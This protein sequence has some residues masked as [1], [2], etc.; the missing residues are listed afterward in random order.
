[1]KK[2]LGLSVAILVLLAGCSKE[3]VSV[4]QPVLKGGGSGTNGGYAWGL[5]TE[6]SGS[7]SLTFPDSRSIKCTWKNFGD[8]GF[9]KGWKPSSVKTVQYQFTEKSGTMN[10]IGIYGWTRNPLLE[11]YIATVGT[12]SG[13]TNLGTMSSYGFT[14]NCRKLQRVNAP[15]I[16]GTKTF[17]QA[18]NMRQ[19]QGGTGGTKTCVMSDHVNFWKSKGISWGS[20][21]YDVMVECESWAGG[22]GSCRLKILN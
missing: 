22:S 10:F 6:G 9:G 20:S 21:V 15:S 3:E 1:M 19:S 12:S 8:I 4:N 17:Y 5:Y 13:G 7:Y 18:K 11:Y 16:E 2:L 14:Y